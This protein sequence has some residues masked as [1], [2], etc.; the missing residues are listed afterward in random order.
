MVQL[1]ENALELQILVD[2]YKNAKFDDEISDMEFYF[3]RAYVLALVQMHRGKLEPSVPVNILFDWL[4][5]SIVKRQFVPCDAIIEKLCF[6]YRT[7][8][9]VNNEKANHCGVPYFYD[10]LGLVGEYYESCGD[11]QGYEK[12]LQAQEQ[13]VDTFA[14]TEIYQIRRESDFLP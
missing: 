9:Y 7:H 11:A 3:R 4:E 2:N 13:W 10:L 5:A 6:Y 8:E 1:P 12:W 14:Q